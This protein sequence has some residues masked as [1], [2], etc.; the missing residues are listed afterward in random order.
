VGHAY[1]M[2]LNLASCMK[3]ELKVQREYT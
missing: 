3:K 1:S 2:H